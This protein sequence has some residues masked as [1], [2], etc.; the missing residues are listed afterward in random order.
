[1][2]PLIL[3]VVIVMKDATCHP[4]SFKE[5]DL[6]VMNWRRMILKVGSEWEIRNWHLT[7]EV[8]MG[9]E[10]PDV[11]SLGRNP[12]KSK[13]AL[14]LMAWPRGEHPSATMPLEHEAP[15]NALAL[16]GILKTLVDGTR[17][18]KL[19]MVLHVELHMEPLMELH[20][21]LHKYST[22]G[23]PCEAPYGLSYW[24]TANQ[25]RR[26]TRNGQIQR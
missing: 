12:R 16:P 22:P 17:H 20:M 25:A 23:A 6:D 13:W 7:K 24:L 1:M 4:K 2:S 8:K 3:S 9:F 14:I 21:Q 19:R 11:A 5:V 10:K 18:E 26:Q 15:A